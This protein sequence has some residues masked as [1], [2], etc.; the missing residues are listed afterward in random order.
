MKNKKHSKQNIIHPCLPFL[1]ISLGLASTGCIA[2]EDAEFDPSFLQHTPGKNTIDVRRFSQGNPIQAGQY[3]ADIYLNDNW[4]GR[5]EVLF[6]GTDTPNTAVLC[7]TP[8]LLALIDLK[9]EATHKKPAPRGC[10]PFTQNIPDAKV[11]FDLSTLKLNIEIPQAL[12]AIRPRG[13]ISPSQWQSGVPAAFVHYNAN[14]YQYQISGAKNNQTYL[15]LRGGVNFAGWA[16][17]HRGSENWNN[18]HSEGYHAIETNI[19][20][21]IAMLR[22]QLTA[23]DFTT[24]GDLMN[25]ASLRGIRLASDDRMLPGSLRGYAPVIRGIANSN[26]KVTIRQGGNI[27]YETTVPAGPFIISDLYPSGYSG[28]LYITVTES[29]GQSRTFSVPFSSVAQLIRP[30][31]TRWQ[32]ATG[33][34]RYGNETYHDTVF[35]GTF[36][37]GLTNDI[38]LNTGITTAPHYMAGLGGFAFNTPMG[39][40]ASDMTWSRTTFTNSDTTRK[41]Y[42]LHT[43]YSVNVPATNTN[44]TLAA[45]RYSSKDFY[46]LQDAIQ[47]NNSDFIDDI[48][49][50]SIA[51]YRPKNQFQLSVNQELSNG[52]GNIYLTG[53]TYSYWGHSGH[54]NEYQIGYNNY[55]KS[56]NYQIGFSQSRDNQ[57]QQRD[58]RLYLNFS[59]PFGNETQSPLLSS[60]MNLNKGGDNSIQTSLSGTKGEDNQF[61]YGL[62][63]S[64]QKEGS[65]S[66]SVNGG[67]RAP[68]V[69]LTASAGSDSDNNRQMSLDASGAIVAHPYGLTLSNDLSDT[70]TIVHAKGAKGAVINNA[71]GQRLDYWGNGIIPYV[72]PYEKNQVSIDPGHLP[73][74]VELSATQQEIIP[75]ANSATLVTFNTRTGKSIL[76]DIQLQDG[77]VPPMAS[78]VFDDAGKSVGYIAQGGRLFT[79]GLP[80]N[81]KLNV[82]WGSDKYSRCSFRY[83]TKPEQPNKNTL[84]DIQHAQ[85]TKN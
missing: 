34:Y 28:E 42:S 1:L 73:V 40:I 82:V 83:H 13:Y 7:L 3:Y 49:I 44:V 45:Y 2:A 67:Y 32:V 10:F 15:G 81:G 53:S 55:W 11:H 64:L 60:T 5:T 79:R 71:P 14:H 21:D 50:K 27:I 76:F 12:V 48:S 41:G 39:A 33:R 65:S 29:G 37:Y 8:E 52:W 36:Q 16:F 57:S 30:G 54:R 68:F 70:F 47:A 62:S 75:R 72:T 51:F 84:T 35:Q 56:L 80:E 6:S 66:Y 85:C 46:N 18:G 22:A 31:Y 26:A 17:R 59:L 20:H 63:T 74:D 78:E 25:S 69:N 77:S 24:S 9:Q 43:S 19:Q 58:D 61:S 38:T 4:K 23:G